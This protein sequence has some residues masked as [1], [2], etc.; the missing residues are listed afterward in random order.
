MQY[1]ITLW[2]L[3]RRARLSYFFPQKE[4]SIDPDMALLISMKRKWK[5]AFLRDEMT[6]ESQQS[7][8]LFQCASG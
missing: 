7:L 4:N 3:L 5:T 8:Y 6:I 2:K 1:R